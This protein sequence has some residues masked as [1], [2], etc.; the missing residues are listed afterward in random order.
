M[1]RRPQSGS[2]IRSALMDQSL[3]LTLKPRNSTLATLSPVLK[4]LRLLEEDW[5]MAEFDHL[6]TQM[7]PSDEKQSRRTLRLN[8]GRRDFCLVNGSAAG[9][10]DFSEAVYRGEEKWERRRPMVAKHLCGCESLSGLQ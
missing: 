3:D 7:V 9:G 6:H 8:R 2:L 5:R 1:R 10:P 4:R